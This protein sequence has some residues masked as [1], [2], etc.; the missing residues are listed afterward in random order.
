[1]RR[2]AAGGLTSFDN[3]D[4][5]STKEHPHKNGRPAFSHPA[6]LQEKNEIHVKKV[7]LLTNIIFCSWLFVAFDSAQTLFAA[8][9][10]T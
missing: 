2:A 7:L 6:L 1:M 8:C 5:F 4:F 3:E 9:L 10:M